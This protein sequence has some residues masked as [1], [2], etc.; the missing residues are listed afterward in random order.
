M[1][2]RLDSLNDKIRRMQSGLTLLLFCGIL[3]SIYYVAIN[4]ITVG[5]YPGYQINSQTVSELSAIGAPSRHIWVLLCSIYSF[6]VIA[7]GMGIFVVTEGN[8]KLT[9]IGALMFFY[10]VSGFFWPP[11]HQREVIAAGNGT[12]TDT[13]HLVFAWVTVG[14]MM[15][16]IG[17][18][19]FSL[20][21]K[22]RIFSIFTILILIVFGILTGIEGKHIRTGEPTPLI[23][24][25]ER[26]N[27][28]AFMLW[29]SVL[30]AALLRSKKSV[31][32]SQYVSSGAIEQ[33]S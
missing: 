30:S 22:F 7:F 29:T 9:T 12:I 1:I 5:Y 20:G 33:H 32:A 25:W 17:L 16:M 28:G 10:G 19:V 4:I 24:I 14:L 21:N 27:I 13:L 26:I 6:L 11:M 31:E 8:K 3:S 18:G 15:V 2:L 23:G